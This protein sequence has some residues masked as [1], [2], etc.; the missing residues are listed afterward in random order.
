VR[1]LITGGGSGIGAACARAFA[2]RGD[3]VAING[4]RRE[5]L[6]ALAGEIGALVAPGDCGESYAAEAI[7]ARALGE[8]GGLDCLVLS[9]G[10]GHSGSVLEQTPESW[11]AVMRTNLD[12]AFLVARAALP[13]LIE[14]RGSVVAIASQ[15]ARRVGTRSAAYCASKAALVMLTQTIAVD[16]GPLGVRANAVC[17]AWTVTPMGDLAMDELAA[18]RGIDREAAYREANAAVPARRAAAPEEVA[19]LVLWL[20]G[21]DSGYL[22]GAS[23]PL[24]GGGGLVDVA[25]L[26]FAQEQP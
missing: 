11:R 8:L 16:F 7:V 13:A 2:A 4:R 9:A 18:R 21:D 5:P 20:A 19:A 12:G 26:A 22:N 14:A 25:T 10:V 24:D 6:E 15:A 3:R 1:V 17:P 23:I